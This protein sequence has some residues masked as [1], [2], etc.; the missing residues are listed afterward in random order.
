MMNNASVL[1][2]DT[3]NSPSVLA[4]GRYVFMGW[5]A[6][7]VTWFRLWGRLPGVRVH[8]GYGGQFPTHHG[9]RPG[10]ASA[11][12]CDGV[13]PAGSGGNGRLRRRRRGRD[14]AVP[15]TGCAAGLHW[16]GYAGSDEAVWNAHC[17]VF[18]HTDSGNPTTAFTRAQ[19]R[20]S[21][22]FPSCS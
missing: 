10:G 5:F 3:R 14:S 18:F 11:G 7:A 12:R 9:H 15:G 16:S 13:H 2:P 6:N 1:G 8:G 22:S 19:W 21:S 20:A 4:C 17:E